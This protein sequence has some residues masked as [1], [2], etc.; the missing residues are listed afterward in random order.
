M[1][2]SFTVSEVGDAPVVGFRTGVKQRMHRLDIRRQGTSGISYTQRCVVAN[3]DVH[4]VVGKSRGI[5]LRQPF[6]YYCIL[7]FR[8]RYVLTST[9][10]L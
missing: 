3:T 8:N 7:D 10:R 6:G 1:I 5:Y 9:D 2:A 4:A